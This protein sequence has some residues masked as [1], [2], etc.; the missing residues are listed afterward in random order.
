[1]D[2]Q[3]TLGFVGLGTMG[4][5]MALNLAK[6]GA[7]LIVWNR[8][9]EKCEPLRAAGATV[10]A[11]LD[12]VFSHAETV[13]L[14]LADEAAVDAVLARGTADFAERVA[15]RTIVHMGTVSPG[16]S[17]GL[18]ADIRA[19]G[20]RYVEAPVSGSRKPAEA[21]QLV[22]M[23]AGEPAAVDAVRPLL[24]PLCHQTIACGPVPN[25]LLMK[26]ASNALLLPTVVAVAEAFHLADRFGLDRQLFAEVIGGGQLASPIA[27]VKAQ[28]LAAGDF[29]VQ[30][31]VPDALKNNR[32]AAEAAR[33]ANA[34]SPLLDV[35]EALYAET[36][37]LGLGDADLVAVLRAIEARSAVGGR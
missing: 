20:G 21:G 17:Q 36:L 8:S 5:L 15:G 12:E 31:A 1:M 25:G 30:A 13:I 37:A 16:Y 14:M 27:R 3:R 24:A 11:S 33:A 34:A 35:T 7:P 9:A 2:D 28:K 6:A 29:A 23:L 26:L 22:A 32:L 10:A 4:Q 18:E 19:A